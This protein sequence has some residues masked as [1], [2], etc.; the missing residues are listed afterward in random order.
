MH[1]SDQSFRIDDFFFCVILSF[2]VIVDFIVVNGDMGL[3]RLA[4]KQRN[5]SL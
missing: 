3:G 1:C 2:G 5:L 4:W